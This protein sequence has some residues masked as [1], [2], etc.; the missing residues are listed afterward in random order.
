MDTVILRVLDVL[1]AFPALVL[2]LVIAEGLG[3]SELHVIWALAVFS[4]P[5]FGRVAR[6]ATLTLRELPFMI[7]AR[8]SGTAAGGSSPA[9]C[10]RTSCPSS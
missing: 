2:A 10:C 1:I 8:L 7:A 4:I 6:G 5:A 9:T 3:P